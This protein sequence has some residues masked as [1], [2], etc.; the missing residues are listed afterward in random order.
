VC[1]EHTVTNNA[2]ILWRVLLFSY[3]ENL[4]FYDIIQD[5]MIMNGVNVS[6]KGHCGPFE[7]TTVICLEK[8]RNIITNLRLANL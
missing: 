6:G 5:E 7:G 4:G 3:A 2:I 1:H 8:L